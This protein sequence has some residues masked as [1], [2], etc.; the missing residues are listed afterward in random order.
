MEG[1]QKSLRLASVGQLGTG[2]GSVACHRH[3]APDRGHVDNRSAAL[4]E[5]GRSACVIATWPKRL[6]SNR[7][8]HSESGS[9]SMGALTWIPASLTRARSGRAEFSD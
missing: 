3:L 6:P 9:G 5:R 1:F 2:V 7:R 4:D 8:R